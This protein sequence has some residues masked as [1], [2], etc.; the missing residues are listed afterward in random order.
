M[1]E[2]DGYREPHECQGCERQGPFE[3]DFNQ[4]EFIDQQVVRVQEPLERTK[5]GGGANTSMC[6]SMMTWSGG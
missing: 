3:L 1:S 2:S 5:G 6:I 4:S